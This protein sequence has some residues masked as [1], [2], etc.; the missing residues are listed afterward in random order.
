MLELLHKVD[1]SRN[2]GAMMQF[3]SSEYN[4]SSRQPEAEKSDGFGHL[5]HSKSSVSQGFGLQLGPPSQKLRVLDH[6]LSSQ[7][8]QDTFSS[9]TS[10]AAGMGDKGQQMVPSRSVQS[11]HSAEKAQVDF[12]LGRSATMG[13][14]SN[15]SSFYKTPESFISALHSGTPHSREIVRNQQIASVSGQMSMTQ[16]IDSFNGNALHPAQRK[17]SVTLLPDASSSF[18]QDNLAFRDDSLEKLQTDSAPSNV[19][20]KSSRKFTMPGAGISQQGNSAHYNMWT[21]VPKLQHNMGVQS[22]Q[23]STRNPE[24]PLPNIVESSSASLMQGCVNYEA[25]ANGEDIRLKESSGQP[26]A[27][28][29]T[30]TVTNMVKPFGQALS[31]KKPADDSPSSSVFKPKDTETFGRSLKP[32]IISHQNYVS[33]NQMEV[34][35]DGEI[36]SGHRAS[37]R[38]RGPDN[39]EDVQQGALRAGQ[40]KEYNTVV[41]ASTGSINGQTEDCKSLGFSRPPDILQTKVSHQGNVASDDGLGLKRDVSQSFSCSDHMTSVRADHPLVSLSPQMA[42]SWFSRYGTFSNGQMLQ[43][44]GAQQVSPLKP[45][46]TPSAKASSDLDHVNPE[47]RGTAAPS[48]EMN[49]DQTSSL[50]V[51]GNFTSLWSPQQNVTGQHQVVLRPK[52]RIKASPELHPWHKE[53]SHDSQDLWS[54]RWL[55]SV[56]FPSLSTISSVGLCSMASLV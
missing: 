13:P 24:S 6:S 39:I 26:L 11:F 4:S 17:P 27:S 30:D 28:V 33:K 5:Q 19:Q 21:D 25:V 8:D 35:K 46:E 40:H 31:M 18:G 38:M 34:L 7:N 10:A 54:L 9:S 49:N 3:R 56:Y 15:E 55:F 37:K 16:H 29:N 1:Q 48:D 50:V 41:G 22:Q 53:I 52:K 44:Y 42:S 2:D 14:G 51:N 20:E 36:D 47:V 32:N 12:G 43:K 23:I 45:G